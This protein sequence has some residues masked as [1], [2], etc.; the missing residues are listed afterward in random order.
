[1][2][3]RITGFF[4]KSP[5]T[6]SAP[7]TPAPEAKRAAVPPVP[8]ATAQAA[9]QDAEKRLEADASPATA[10]EIARRAEL[11]AEMRCRALER[12]AEPSLLRELALGDKVARVRLAAAERL[13][14][15]EDLEALRRDST[16]KAV[17]RHA[18]E[19]LKAL[20]AREAGER[21]TRARIEHLLNSLEQHAKRHFEPLYDARLDSLS[22]SWSAVAAAATPAERERFVELSMLCRQTVEQHLAGLAAREEAIAARLELIAACNELEQV[23]RRLRDEDLSASASAVA[24]LRVTQRTRWEEAAARTAVDEPLARRYRETLPVIDAW[25]AST[26][27]IPAIAAQV[28]ELAQ[29]IEATATPGIDQLDDWQEQLDTLAARL[30]WPGSLFAPPVV[31]EIDALRRRLRELQRARQADV[32]EQ[33]AQVRR[34]RQALRRLIDEGQL[35]VATRTRQWIQKRLD[36][37]PPAETGAE[38]AAL[39]SLDEALAR[40][41]DWYEFAS[42]PKKTELC[43]QAEALAG[44]TLDNSGGNAADASGEASGNQADA[45]RIAA[46]GAQVRALRDRWNT[47]CAADPDADPELRARFDAAIA[48]AYAPCT[49]FYAELRRRQDENLT[50]RN[51]FCEAL[52]AEITAI[53]P[54]RADWKA[55]EQR[56]RALRA[57]WKSHEPVRW[58]E[59]RES[60]ER[61]G[62]LIGRLRAMLDEA[63]AKGLARRRELLA[64]A[65][66]LRTHEPLDA[67]IAQAKQLPEAWKQA[68]FCDPRED[69]QLWP[70][71]RG[72]LDAVFQRRDDARHAE[73]A[74]REAAEA[75]AREAQAQAEARRREKERHQHES[76][77]REI[78]LADSVARAESAHAANAAGD[79]TSLDGLTGALDALPARSALAQALRE[80]IAALRNGAPFEATRLAENGERLLALTLDLEILADLPTPAEFAAARMERKVALL[81]ASL[82]GNRPEETRRDLIDQ[83]LAT[84]PVPAEVRA[85]CRGRVE[86]LVAAPISA[87]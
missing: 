30:H 2:L 71:F 63:R 42:V 68:G 33:L 83:W 39:A 41:H 59:A 44:E 17:Q 43:E 15:P 23:V 19:A 76:R 8:D 70:S 55:L 51:G 26:A 32:R 58:P 20:R 22:T 45:D 54:A 48:R 78:D 24:A 56:E 27:E 25:L 82:R 60:H 36:E 77:Q 84:G 86:G 64:A 5:A 52:D 34:R 65:E 73:R 75:A 1:M 18:R 37:L 72:A 21:E 14:Q 81:A 7:A 57:E 9:A 85:A 53:D 38:R 10:A 79:A 13:T 62:T 87:G 80:R 46:R 28:P 6:P 12:V 67:A 61:F 50:W 74:E 11:P 3:D 4:R 49:A 47:L 31:A 66:A 69:R 40:L 35:R 16:D 29:R